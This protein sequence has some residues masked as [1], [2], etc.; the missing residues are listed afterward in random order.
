MKT[1]INLLLTLT[2]ITAI[3]A[4]ETIN[5]EQGTGGSETD[6]SVIYQRNCS[7][8]HGL[9]GERVAGTRKLAETELNREQILNI[10][11]NGKGGM[12]AFK[13]TLSEQELQAV[14]D[15]VMEL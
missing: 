3:I 5:K 12:P 8:C 9:E 1:S 13:E 6:G 4:C 2:A 7:V 11:K 14:T 10:T 15:F